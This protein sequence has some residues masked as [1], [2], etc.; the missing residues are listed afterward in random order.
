MAGWDHVHNLMV[1]VGDALDLEQVSEFAAE[2]AWHLVTRC[3]SVE[4]D[5]VDANGRLFLTA[6]AG[7]LDPDRQEAL[8]EELLLFNGAAADPRGVRAG[9]A[10]AAGEVVILADAPVAGL[11]ATALTA[12]VERLCDAALQW[13]ARIETGG[14]SGPSGAGDA[15]TSA[16]IRG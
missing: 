16:V 5:Y 2:N 9:F 11:T 3:G 10:A 7:T 4:V 15:L 8:F 13:R 1:D 12:L 6:A 14:A